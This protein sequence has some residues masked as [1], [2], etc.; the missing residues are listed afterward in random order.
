MR[1]LVGC[2]LFDGHLL[3]RRDMLVKAR[4]FLDAVGGRKPGVCGAFA[5]RCG[6]ALRGLHVFRG[7]GFLAWRWWLVS[8]GHGA[9]LCCGSWRLPAERATK[10]RRN[11]AGGRTRTQL[12]YLIDAPTF[13]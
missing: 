12:S 9:F 13:S 2:P 6:S 1:V 10:R 11:S 7:D 5:G 4:G 3:H 8:G